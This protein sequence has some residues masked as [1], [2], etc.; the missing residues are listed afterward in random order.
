MSGLSIIPSENAAV[1]FSDDGGVNFH[2]LPGISG[3]SESPGE[4]PSSEIR[5]FKATAQQTGSPA[6]P[7]ISLDVASFSPQ[8]SSWRRALASYKSKKTVTFK[9]ATE[10][11]NIFGPTTDAADTMAVAANTGVVTLAGDYPDLTD[12]DYATGDAF[13]YDVAGTTP[14]IL[15]IDS[16]LG[17]GATVAKVTD[18]LTDSF[19]AAAL[20]AKKYS[21]ITPGLELVFLGRIASVPGLGNLSTESTLTGSMN[22]ACKSL[23]PSPTLT[24]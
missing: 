3:W 21:I 16:L 9:F 14:K 24:R 15:T 1:S 20:T 12:D 23:L 11:L 6:P 4:A 17:T 13:V 10:A 7:T 18:P 8:H 2:E 19:P 5:S 22:I